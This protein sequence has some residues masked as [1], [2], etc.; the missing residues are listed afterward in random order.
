[1]SIQSKR[2]ELAL[3]FPWP[4][5]LQRRF[6]QANLM[7]I[8]ENRSFF[9]FYSISLEPTNL[10]A[11]LYMYAEN[12]FCGISLLVGNFFFRTTP[13]VNFSVAGKLFSTMKTIRAKP[14]QSSGGKHAEET[15]KRALSRSQ[16]CMLSNLSMFILLTGIEKVE[17]EVNSQKVVVT[18]YVH[19]NKILKAV[20]RGGLKADFWS[21]QNEILF[22][23]YASG[24]YG[25]MNSFSFFQWHESFLHFLVFSVSFFFIFFKGFVIILMETEIQQRLSGK[26]SD[27]ILIFIS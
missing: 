4:N 24:S 18:G 19:R 9:P 27:A 21:A 14:A 15:I 11:R 5:M 25:R 12:Q 1:M 6:V 17:V 10:R 8:Y 22:N 23:A 2:Y 26:L 13:N 20:R 7:E 16:T 3:F